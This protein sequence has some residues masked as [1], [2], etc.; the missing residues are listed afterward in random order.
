[1]IKLFREPQ[2]EEKTVIAADP[3]D[4]GSSYCAA[5]AKSKKHN[6]TFMLFHGRGNSA[7]FGYELYKMA[8]F[9]KKKTKLWPLIGVERNI[10][11][12]TIYVL[13]ELH[14]PRLYRQMVFNPAS[15]REEEKKVG[16]VTN[17]ESR[18]RMLDDLVLSLKQG[19]NRIYD[20]ETVREMM[21]FIRNPNTG[22]PEAARGANDDLVIA[23]A[24]AWQLL[25]TAKFTVLDDPQEII[26]QAPR[27]KLFD[28]RG[29][30]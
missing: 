25:Q 27:Q 23:E 9:I 30:Y 13:Q 22:K 4:E 26:K 24:I 2:L 19:I 11:A 12:A 15:Q 17:M 14:Y 20:V 1:M 28:K 10:G 3:A 6:D 8:L 16:W 5:V 18:R 29:F 7:D 21:R